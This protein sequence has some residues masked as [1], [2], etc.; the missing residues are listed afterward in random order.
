MGINIAIG[1][2]INNKNP[3]K[4][5]DIGLDKSLIEYYTFEDLNN[6]DKPDIVLG[7]KKKIPL[8]LI[9]FKY[10]KTSGFGGYKLDF[11][12]TNECIIEHGINII[13]S[14]FN[15]KYNKKDI[16]NLI[17][18]K[19]S[20]TKCT[21]ELKGLNIANDSIE[22]D[23]KFYIEVIY[24][25]GDKDLYF[26]DSIILL[27]DNADKI[28]INTQNKECNINIKQ[29]SL[30][31][32]GLI[33]N[34]IDNYC[35][36]DLSKYGIKTIIIKYV[37]SELNSNILYIFKDI[38]NDKLIRF[39]N[40]GIP[41]SNLTNI[42]NIG[43][44]IA[45]NNIDSFNSDKPLIIGANNNTFL[46][47]YENFFYGILYSI[48]FYSDFISI[49]NLQ[50]EIDII[51]PI[52]ENYNKAILVPVRTNFDV[53]VKN[54]KINTF[55]SR[56]CFIY[57]DTIKVVHGY[58]IITDTS[59]IGKKIGSAII[60]KRSYEINYTIYDYTLKTFIPPIKLYYTI[61]EEL[62]TTGYSLILNETDG[63][64]SEE[65]IPDEKDL[66]FTGQNMREAGV[67]T[68]Y[69]KYRLIEITSFKIVITNIVDSNNKIMIDN[70]NKVIIL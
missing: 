69:I 54:E 51:D 62:D 29:L 32:T 59:T 66:V 60:N 1:N 68:V 18:F 42:Y 11:T 64:N 67:T 46:N 38:K 48:A 5:F 24:I 50:K 17:D 3:S 7:K 35:L 70:N 15:F 9:N 23:N 2:I 53:Y 49:D 16:I 36:V 25:N 52:P 21:L 55:S 34:G 40:Y 58:T 4:S 27:K 56:I 37:L 61:G 43:T 14:S 13:N 65:F 44:C 31:N 57:N 22:D 19:T 28:N 6:S 8:N 47:R 10:N 20:N 45:S 12:N 33:F 39:Q 30:T 63:T 41:F 26:K